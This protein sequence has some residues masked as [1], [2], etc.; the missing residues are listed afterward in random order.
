MHRGAT[1][2]STAFRY[3][4]NSGRKGAER[5][6][7]GGG[8]VYMTVMMVMIVMVMVTVVAKV[9]LAMMMGRMMSL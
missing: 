8:V 4:K 7:D 3:L 9:M 5:G 6:C 1:R 2:K